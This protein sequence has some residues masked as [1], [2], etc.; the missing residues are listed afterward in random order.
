MV[1]GVGLFLASGLLALEEGPRISPNGQVYMAH[2]S[3]PVIL[4]PAILGIVAFCAGVVV[5]VRVLLK[6]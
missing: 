1:L 6:R 5:L 2:L 4:A 3:P